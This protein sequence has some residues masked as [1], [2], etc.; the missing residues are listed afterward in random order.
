MAKIS[1][2]ASRRIAKDKDRISKIAKWL[3]VVLCVQFIIYL[4]L[5]NIIPFSND[6]NGDGSITDEEINSFYTEIWYRSKGAGPSQETDNGMQFIHTYNILFLVVEIGLCMYYMVVIMEE[7]EGSLQERIKQFFHENKGL[8]FLFLFMTWTF[9][10]SL[11]AYDKFRSF[12][13]CYNLRDGYVSF[14]FYGSVLTC[15]LL[16]GKN[17]DKSKRLVTNI[18]LVT[19]TIIAIL[20]LVDYYALASGKPV[21]GS[22][23]IVQRYLLSL[24]NITASVFNNSN[25]YGYFLSIA[26]I[27]A[28]AMFVKTEIPSYE[29]KKSFWIALTSKVLYAISFCVMAYM[30]IL[31]DTFGSY[32]GVMLG[33]V[34]MFITS[35][36]MKKDFIKTVI[37]VA[38]FVVLSI[39]VQNAEGIFVARRNFENT[40]N[41]ILKIVGIYTNRGN[42]ENIENSAG[43]EETGENTG[44]NTPATTNATSST[45]VAAAGSGRYTLWKNTV[46]IIMG[47]S[48]ETIT[49]KIKTFFLGKGLENLIYTLK[50]ENGD[51]EG[52]SHSLLFQLAGTT[53]VPGAILYFLGIGWIFIS[54]LKN[55]KKWDAF[56]YMGMAVIVSYII[57]SMT[58]NSGFYT[59]GYFYIF[60]GF[61]ILG[62]MELRDKESKDLRIKTGKNK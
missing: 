21:I 11:C 34:F 53:G 1:G 47:E 57:S 51:S 54:N 16:L 42:S 55:I 49:G 35:L 40:T 30:L 13:G 10:S 12:I 17:S 5:L 39:Y 45:D 7:Y 36:I 8:F 27:V 43:I 28:A 19:A 59:S 58:G 38:V 25:H 22:I 29:N 20:T 52:R 46:K 60:V 41:D 48:D 61:V 14:M 18:F 15:V 6:K 56:S 23:P 33:L 3:L 32:L 26:V 31:N 44:N 9:I 50:N 2:K 4:F 37:V 24:T 62:M